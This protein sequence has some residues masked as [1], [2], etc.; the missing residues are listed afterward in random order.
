MILL[1]LLLGQC[2]LRWAVVAVA[3]FAFGRTG[4]SMRLVVRVGQRRWG[5][6]ESAGSAGR[7]RVLGRC[8]LLL[9][10]RRGSAGQLVVRVGQRLIV[11]SHRTDSFVVEQYYCSVR[12]RKEIVAVVVRPRR[13]DWVCLQ[14]RRMLTVVRSLS[15]AVV[16]LVRNHLAVTPP[17]RMGWDWPAALLQLLDQRRAWTPVQKPVGKTVQ[18]LTVRKQALLPSVKADRNRCSGLEQQAVR[19]LKHRHLLQMA[20]RTRSS[21]LGLRVGRK[22]SLRHRQQKPDRTLAVMACRKQRPDRTWMS[23]LPVGQKQACQRQSSAGLCWKADQSQLLQ[24]LQLAHRR[25]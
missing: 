24:V 22:L 14:R 10:C 20:A 7:R 2:R 4:F 18:M 3:V 9:L 5:P 13:R 12:L 19:M 25:R 6:V 17:L 11:K 23:G 15:R 16:Q 21:E 8:L 1:L